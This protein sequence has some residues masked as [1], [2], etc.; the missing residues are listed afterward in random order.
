[1]ISSVAWV[2]KGAAK[3]TPES[4]EFTEEELTALQAEATKAMGG[5]ANQV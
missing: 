4:I 3:K 5:D 2:P 1:M